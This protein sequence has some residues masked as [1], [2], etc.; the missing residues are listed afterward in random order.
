VI[1]EVLDRH[2]RGELR[3]AHFVDVARIHLE[4]GP[5]ADGVAVQGVAVG[6]GSELVRIAVKVSE[7]S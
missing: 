2:A 6:G 5:A 1:D 4:G 7:S 3:E